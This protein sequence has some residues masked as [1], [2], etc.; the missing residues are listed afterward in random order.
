VQP[1]ADI[2]LEAPKAPSAEAWARMS[3]AQRERAIEALLASESVEE[4]EEREAMAEGDPHLDA[5]MGIRN[6][7]RS[8]FGRL[9]RRIYIGANIKVY[10]PD[11]KGFTPDVIA[12]TDVDPGRRDCWMVSQEGKG[13][14]LAFEV[15]Y[16]GNRYKD[17]QGNVEKYASLGIHEYFVYDIR[18]RLLKA[19]ELPRGGAKYLPIPPRAG[20][21]HSRMLEL[22]VALE[23]EEVRFYLGEA[24]LVTE[25]ETVTKLQHMLDSAVSRAD[26]QATRADEQAA[27]AD[28]AAA[29]LASAVLTILTVRGLEVRPEVRAEILGCADM[30]T[31]ERWVELAATAAACEDLFAGR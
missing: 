25:T 4:I 18:R 12:V 2:P 11:A 13:V 22:D 21:F 1:D 6:T 26:E 16:K 17:L 27:R 29:R 31:L 24:I 23:D 5:K 30:P 28:Q 14:D 7:L 15:H 20:R 19:Y 10:Y 9:G 3:P 8:H